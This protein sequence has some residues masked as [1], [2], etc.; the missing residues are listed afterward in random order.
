MTVMLARVI[1]MLLIGLGLFRI[2]QRQIITDFLK[3]FLG[4]RVWIYRYSLVAFPIAVWLLIT[5]GSWE[6]V[7]RTVITLVSSTLLLE[8]VLY[9]LAPQR[10]LDAIYRSYQRNDVYYAV[11][12][13][14]LL[15][16]CYLLL[17]RF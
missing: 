8:A 5:Q 3:E 9:M 14:F 6:N 16:G 1:G 17:V 7:P 13:S 10:T 15:T 12:I 2:L 4:R 11:A